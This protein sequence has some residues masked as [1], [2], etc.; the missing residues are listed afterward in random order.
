MLVRQQALPSIL[1]PYGSE[2]SFGPGALCDKRA[3]AD[4]G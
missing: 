3:S 2:A 4:V 1:I